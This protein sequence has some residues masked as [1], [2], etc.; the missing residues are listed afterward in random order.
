MNEQAPMN[1][2]DRNRELSRLREDFIDSW[3][4]ELEMEMDDDRFG[5]R[6]ASRADRHFHA[7]HTSGCSDHAVHHQLEFVAVALADC[8]EQ[9]PACERLHRKSSLRSGRA[10]RINRSRKYPLLSFATVSVESRLWRRPR[11]M[12]T[13]RPCRSFDRPGQGLRRGR[14]LRGAVGSGWRD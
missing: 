8:D 2:T 4:E 5:G 1:E 7:A 10:M 12:T 9:H 14:S 13:L 6:G 11:P 3:D